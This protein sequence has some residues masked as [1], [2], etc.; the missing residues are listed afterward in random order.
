VANALS[1]E[2]TEIQ[3]RS[4]TKVWLVGQVAA[5]FTLIHYSGRVANWEGTI[6]DTTTFNFEDHPIKDNSNTRLKDSDRY[7]NRQ[8][9]MNLVQ[10]I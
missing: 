4:A 5:N 2:N 7:K 6:H 8:S 1:A 9:K 10:F 3:T